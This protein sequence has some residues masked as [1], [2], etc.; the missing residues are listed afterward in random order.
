VVDKFRAVIA[1]EAEEGEGKAGA[2]IRE[3]FDN[4]FLG[5]IEEDA[6]FSD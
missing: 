4:P 6:E 2:D 5:F 1:V 3:G